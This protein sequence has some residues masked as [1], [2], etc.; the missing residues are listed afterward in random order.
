TINPEAIGGIS[1]DTTICDGASVTL[2]ANG[3]VTYSWNTSETTPSIVVSP[4]TTTTYTVVITNSFG[5]SDTEQVTVTVNPTPT[6]D[7]GPNQVICDTESAT[8]TATGGT[9]YVW[10]TTETTPSII[11]NP[12]TTTTY[13][14]TVTNAQGCPDVDSVTVTVNASPNADAGADQTICDNESATLTATGGTSYLWST[15]E[16]SQSIIVSPSTTTTYTV[17]VTAANGCTDVASVEVTV[18]VAPSVSASGPPTLC[19]NLPI[20]LDATGVV[21]GASITGYSWSGP[22][23]FT[24]TLE[25]PT[26][27][28]GDAAYPAAGNA[29]YTVTVTDANGCT[30][31]ATVIINIQAPPTISAFASPDFCDNEPVQL[32]A[33]ASAVGASITGFLWS[34]PNG[35]SSTAEDPVINPGDAGYPTAGVNTYYVTVTDANGCTDS[36]SVM[37]NILASPSVSASASA[38]SCTDE[39]ILFNATGSA[40]D[41]SIT[42]YVWSGPFGFSSTAEDPILN[43]GDAAY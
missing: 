43:P 29:S 35:F 37:I 2:T 17:T 10:S 41:G 33:T 39:S 25:D 6:V 31:E 7:A 5:C 28:P 32:N 24:S 15:T 22:N 11:V 27:N 42:G 21:G 13:Y 19:G 9:S 40:G 3:G 36:A 4:S 26:I 8:L 12:S 20:N 38:T 23:G 14:V 30:D 18:Q 16:T 1:N 34:G